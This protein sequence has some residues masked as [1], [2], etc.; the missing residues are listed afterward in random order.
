MGTSAP[1]MEPTGK[2][3]CLILGPVR[4][5]R[6]SWR[7]GS[8]STGH[9]D[10]VLMS[11]TGSVQ[12]LIMQSGQLGS[13]RSARLRHFARTGSHCSFYLNSLSLTVSL[14]SVD[15]TASRYSLV[16]GSLKTV[17]DTKLSGILSGEGRQVRMSRLSWRGL[18]DP[19][20]PVEARIC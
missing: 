17:N 4:W 18:H 10:R 1:A 7:N 5:A 19:C 16:I 8:L 20:I 9:V 14:K 6:K 13:V 12:R 3:T 11:R 2:T 15:E